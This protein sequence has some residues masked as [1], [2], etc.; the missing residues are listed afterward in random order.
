MAIKDR[1]VYDLERCVCKVP[2]ACSDCSKR[3]EGLV[4]LECM[5][6][7]MKDALELLKIQPE[8]VHCKDCRNGAYV[9]QIGT[10]GSADKADKFCKWL[11]Y[12]LGLSNDEKAVK[13]DD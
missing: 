12:L 9:V 13:W 7:L 11:E 10:F 5:E 8:I 4:P 6:E 2:D 3:R 1:V